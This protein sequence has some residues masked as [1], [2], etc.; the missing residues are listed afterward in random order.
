MTTLRNVL[1]IVLGI[2]WHC[3][4]NRLNVT[5]KLI[6]S[7]ECC[8][9]S[10]H[11]KHNHVPGFGD[12]EYCAD[13]CAFLLQLYLHCRSQRAGRLKSKAS[14]QVSLSMWG[15]DKQKPHVWG[16]PALGKNAENSVAP[17]SS[18]QWQSNYY[19][20]NPFINPVAQFFPCQGWV[21]QQ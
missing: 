7:F 4:W 19:F 14:K 10:P 21:A 16:N 17:N 12:E 8:H 11:I 2:V 13:L 6:N 18:H 20:R 3:P 5:S 1:L 9:K 15:W